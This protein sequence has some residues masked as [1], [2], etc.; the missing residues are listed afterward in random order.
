MDDQ[1]SAAARSPAADED[2]LAVGAR[3]GRY[4]VLGRLGAGGMG[5][6]FAAHD[7]ELDRRIA[8]KLLREGGRDSHARHQRLLAEAQAMA[9]LAHP[10]VVAVHDV[11]EHRGRVFLALELVDGE[12]LASWLTREHPLAERLRV[13]VDAGRGL[14][15]AHAG[16]LVHRDFKPKYAKPRPERP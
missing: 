7:P 1:Q 4:V 16:G 8:L 5:V 14:A 9:R 10:N 2:E 6:V 12:T 13:L 11:G 15:A 3:V